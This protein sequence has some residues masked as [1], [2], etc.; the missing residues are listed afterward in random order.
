MQY[1]KD[2][3]R[4]FYE[5]GRIRRY[6]GNTVVAKVKSDSP[7]YHTMTALY[8]MVTEAGLDDHIILMPHDSYHM[9]VIRGVNDQVRIDT[10]WPASLPK[11]TPMEQVDDYISAAVG[12]VKMPRKVQMKFDVIDYSRSCMKVLLLPANEAD[13]KALKEFR[14]GVAKEIGL[15]LPGHDEYRFHITL[16]YTRIIPEGE[17]EAR[18]NRMIQEMNALIAA[19]EPFEISDPYMAF[20]D[21]MLVFS[22]VRIPRG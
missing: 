5:D 2:I 19:Q 8:R 1:G 11:D 21:D 20:Y 13:A 22:P 14:D 3:G 6:P 17:N 16:G 15:A 18:M 9:T 4:K 7:A 10:H 12:R